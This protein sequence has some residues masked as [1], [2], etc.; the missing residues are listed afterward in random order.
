[1]SVVAF[2]GSELDKLKDVVK[3]MQNVSIGNASG[4][5]NTTVG[6]KDDTAIK[7][8]KLQT[9]MVDLECFFL[10]GDAPPGHFELG[11]LSCIPF[12]P[13]SAFNKARK[14]V[15]EVDQWWAHLKYV[16][17]IDGEGIKSDVFAVGGCNIDLHPRSNTTLPQ[18]GISLINTYIPISFV[19]MIG[20]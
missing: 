16:Y 14:T 5:Y 7:Q 18:Y 3:K 8:K 1:M 11:S 15:D 17:E 4:K 6:G 13:D 9:K 20:Y 12:N 2:T 19:E 10:D